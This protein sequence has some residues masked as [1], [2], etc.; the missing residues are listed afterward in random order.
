MGLVRLLELGKFFE[1][2]YE[3]RQSLVGLRD[4]D[5][6]TKVVFKP[7][8]ILISSCLENSPDEEPTERH[9]HVGTKSPDRA[10]DD[11]ASRSEAAMSIL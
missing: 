2:E 10:C 8:L 5:F 6:M 3:Y 11:H 4:N 1:H 9:Q 7:P